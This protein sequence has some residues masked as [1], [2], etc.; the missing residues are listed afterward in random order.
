MATLTTYLL[1]SGTNDLEAVQEHELISDRDFECR[2]RGEAGDAQM[3]AVQ[4]A[5]EE[6]LDEADDLEESVR[7]FS[8]DVPD[9][10]VVLCEVEERF[11]QVERLRM[12]VFRDGKRGG[13]LEHG[14]IFNVGSG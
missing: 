5:L 9:A 4:F 11:D 3:S 12:V 6:P 14:Y 8:T 1:I 2:D 13:D 7:Q 10:T